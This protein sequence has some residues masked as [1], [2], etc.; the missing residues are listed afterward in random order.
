MSNTPPELLTDEKLR[1]PMSG[2]D[3]LNTLSSRD[4]RQQ[5]KFAYDKVV[6]E[7]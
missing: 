7:K 3:D 2:V 5:Q 6:A 4:Y 1:S